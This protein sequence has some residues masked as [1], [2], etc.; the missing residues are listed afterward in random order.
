MEEVEI[1]AESTQTADSTSNVAGNVSFA[2]S[3]PNEHLFNLIQL[4]SKPTIEPPRALYQA[5]PVILQGKY[6]HVTNSF[7]SLKWA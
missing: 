7:A 6:N 2:H 4:E 3:L 1:P 5:L